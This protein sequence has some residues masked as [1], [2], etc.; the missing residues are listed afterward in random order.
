[1]TNYEAVSIVIDRQWGE[2]RVELIKR[3]DAFFKEYLDA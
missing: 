2:Y 1:M 3:S